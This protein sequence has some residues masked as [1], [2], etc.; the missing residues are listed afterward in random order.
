MW[1]ERLVNIDTLHTFINGF[2]AH[3]YIVL[4]WT[5]LLLFSAWVIVHAPAFWTG[6][7]RNT[8]TWIGL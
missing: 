3:I 6:L 8:L 4:L 7:Q 5:I 2:H 1:Y